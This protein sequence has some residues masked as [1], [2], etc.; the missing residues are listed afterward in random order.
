MA[1]LF[2]GFVVIDGR[3]ALDAAAKIAIL[4]AVIV[5]VNFVWLLAGAALTRFFRDPR[6]NRAINVVFA[7]LLVV[8]V[9]FA[10]VL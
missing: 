10:L 2:S 6:S 4:T 7:G 8:A 3:L 1:A 5:S 9:V